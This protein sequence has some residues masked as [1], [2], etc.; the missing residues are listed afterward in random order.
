MS[1]LPSPLP[2]LA[3]VEQVW[4]ERQLAEPVRAP[5]WR[6]W[7]Y[8]RPAVVLGCSQRRLLAQAREDEGLAV[9]LRGSGGGAVL[10][11]P[12]MLGLSVALPADHPLVA[13]GLLASYRW[14]GELLAA[15]LQDAGVAARALPPDEARGAPAAGVLDWACFAGLSPWEPVA[16]DGRKIAGLAQVRRRHGVLLVGG[17]LLATPDWPLLCAALGQP[18]EQAEALRL[19]TTSWAEQGGVAL[20]AGEL[21]RT[22]EARLARVLR[23]PGG[24][25]ISCSP[26]ALALA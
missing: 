17:V 3:C 16:A 4:N 12:W 2:D 10:V 11:G 19:R 15:V 14:L 6:L 13:P 20:R 7:A 5:A 8:E 9:L 25:V 22:L 24:P 23:P 21:V 1:T 26:E 18:A